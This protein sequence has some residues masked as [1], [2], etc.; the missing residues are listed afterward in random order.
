MA[1]SYQQIQRR[2]N[3]AARVQISDAGGRLD[4]LPVERAGVLA[5]ALLQGLL[6]ESE[7]NDGCRKSP[8]AKRPNCRL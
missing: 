3:L 7:R 6:D 4:S 1:R 8:K 5:P 2:L